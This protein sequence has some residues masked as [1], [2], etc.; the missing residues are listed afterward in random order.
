MDSSDRNKLA[1]AAWFALFGALYLTLMPFDFRFA[2]RDFASV[3]E[4]FTELSFGTMRARSRQQWV[5]NVIMFVPLGF[6]WTGWLT[7]TLRAWTAKVVVAALVV[8]LGVATTVTVEFLQSWIPGRAP[9]L[10][11]MSG[12]ATGALVGALAWLFGAGPLRRGLQAMSRAGRGALLGVLGGYVAIYVVVAW[13]PLDFILSRA[14]WADKLA[15]G[16]WGW[17]SAPLGCAGGLRCHLLRATEV[18]LTLPVGAALGLAWMMWMTPQGRASALAPRALGVALAAIGFGVVME[19]GQLL[20]VSGVAEG[21]AVVTRAIG[22]VI[23]AWLAFRVGE[24]GGFALSRKVRVWAWLAVPPYLLVLVWLNWGGN[25]FR[26]DV[27]GAAEQFAALRFLPFYYHYHVSEAVAIFSVLSHLWMYAPV[28]VLLWLGT[29]DPSWQRSRVG[30]AALLALVLSVVLEGGKL[31]MVGLRPDPSTVWIAMF[32]AAFSG[33]AVHRLWRGFAVGVAESS[34]AHQHAFAKV[35]GRDDSSHGDASGQAAAGAGRGERAS[36]TP[37]TFAP[38]ETG[39]GPECDLATVAGVG[40]ATARPALGGTG[41]AESRRVAGAA[42]SPLRWLWRVLGALCCVLALQQALTWPLAGVALAA[43]LLVYALVLWR[44]PAACLLVIPAAVPVLDLSLHTGRFLYDELDLL[45]LM[46]LGMLLLRGRTLPQAPDA[47]WSGGLRWALGAYLLSLLVATA[48]A[49]WP[50]PPFGVNDWARYDSPYNALRAIKGALWATLIAWLALALHVRP[51]DAWRRWLVPGL[52][53]GL[54]AAIAAVVLER[55]LYP[56]LFDTDSR[57]R[58]TGWFTDMHT[59]GPSIETW[60]VMCLPAVVLWAWQGGW[61]RWVPALMLLSGGLYALL[62]TYSRAGYLAFAVVLV[63]LLLG[64]TFHKG[65]RRGRLAV[66]ALMLLPAGIGALFLP[67]LGGGFA[68]QRMSQVRGDFGQRMTHWSLAMSLRD[69]GWVEQAL[70]AGPGAFPARYRLAQPGGVLPANYGL[71]ADGLGGYVLRIG[72]GDSL[73]INQRLRGIEPGAY[74]LEVEARADVPSRLEVFVCEK[75]IR[76]SYGCHQTALAVETHDST[77]LWSTNLS[78]GEG[79]GPLRRGVVLSLRN[80]RTGS[81][82]DVASIRLT[83]A[84]GGEHVHNGDFSA[85]V[86]HWYF[87][88]DHLDPW[89]VENQYLEVLFDQGWAGLIAFGLLLIAGCGSLAL[90]ALRGRFSDAVALA[91][92]G[93]VLAVGVFS[94][95]FWSPRIMLVFFL[96]LLIAAA[97]GREAAEAFAGTDGEPRQRSA[98]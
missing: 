36:R 90:G 60:L 24:R 73:F 83:D 40:G 15:S 33:W 26:I 12:N 72:T 10:W 41:G 43:G 81:V 58:I 38:D 49:L 62:V 31:F 94:T 42:A 64:A 55:A 11:D 77:L 97:M 21:R 95:V 44:W 1:L 79:D 91:S 22:V 6:F 35:V 5:A 61:R 48:L 39:A 67:Q 16:L 32:A 29:F 84:T 87:T 14:E 56:G 37:F 17:W 34:S 8:G 92:L 70:G 86:T 74:R 88:T 68:E 7:A 96:I 85:G 75:P 54:A 52:A 82:I 65:A 3:W 71:A 28:G 9:S 23:G 25:G 80:G 59:G 89:R 30:L 66:V 53:L 76:H 50:L 27:G 18:V 4:S 57:Y 46:T 13:L 78:L 98:L 20:T 93:G 63:I 47:L 2:E 69:R 51:G 45:L 19:F